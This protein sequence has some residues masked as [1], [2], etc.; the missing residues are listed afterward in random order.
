[1]IE[2]ENIRT[3]DDFDF[4]DK[5]VLIRVD[6]NSPIV[7]NTVRDN[8]RIK[9][10]AKTIQ[11]LRD[12]G[13]KIVVLAHQGRVGDKDFTTLEQH[14]VLLTKYLNEVYYSDEVIGSSAL[15]L[16]RDPDKEI[17]VLENVRFLAEESVKK[18]FEKTIFVNKLKDFFD[19]FV[20]DAYSVS[21]REC[22]STIGFGRVLPSCAGRVMEKEIRNNRTFLAELKRP[23]IYMIGGSKSEELIKLLKFSLE[24]NKVD[25]ILTSGI[26][27]ELFCAASSEAIF[28]KRKEMYETKGLLEDYAKIKELYEKYHDKIKFPLDFAVEEDGVRNEVEADY[29]RDL[30][31]QDVG[32]MTIKEY[33][34]ILLQSGS[35]FVKGPPG[36]FEK[37]QFSKGTKELFTVI[38]SLT[39]SYILLAGGHSN[40]V[41]TEFGISTEHINH[42]SLA[43]GALLDY[44]SGEKLPGVEILRI[45]EETN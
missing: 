43:G 9:E 27:G 44:L 20:N 12:K 42:K 32:S 7:D 17:V 41:F 4:K 40:D 28:Q 23:V 14:T 24:N 16:I 11:E 29:L 6:L 2:E 19:I 18:D 45:K 8:D 15:Q 31:Q 1:M 35:V 38:A 21:H 26:V 10:H 37:P 39:D 30:E 5:K 36:V 34:D 33:S 13:A 25:M 22:T 3:L